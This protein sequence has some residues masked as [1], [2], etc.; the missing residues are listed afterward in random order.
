MLLAVFCHTAIQAQ[1]AD[2]IT[3]LY[4]TV[5]NG[6]ESKMEFFRRADGT[7]RGQIIWLRHSDN[8]DGSPKMDVNNPDER[9]RQV[10]ADRIVLFDGLTFDAKKRVWFGGQFYDPTTGRIFKSDLSFKDDKNLRVK[11]L[12]FSKEIVIEKIQ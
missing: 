12:G 11:A 3:G 4:R 2:R 5:L 7:Y 8:E 9:L 10:R 6:E 1:E